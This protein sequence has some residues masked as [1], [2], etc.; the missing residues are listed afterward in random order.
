MPDR[1]LPCLDAMFG[2]CKNVRTKAARAARPMRIV[3]TTRLDGMEKDFWKQDEAK[4]GPATRLFEPQG[5]RSF[6]Y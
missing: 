6:P 2:R 3:R 5:R 4:P 1:G